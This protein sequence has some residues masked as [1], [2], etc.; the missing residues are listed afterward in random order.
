MRERQ[1]CPK[2]RLANHA[3]AHRPLFRRVQAEEGTCS[4]VVAQERWE[5][6]GGRRAGRWQAG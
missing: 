3:G 6:S 1:Q 2:L 4:R 5:Q